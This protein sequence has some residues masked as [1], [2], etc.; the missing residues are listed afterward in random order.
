MS[1]NA[2]YIPVNCFHPFLPAVDLTLVSEIWSHSFTEMKPYTYISTLRQIMTVK[3]ICEVMDLPEQS[4]KLKVLF[5][6]PGKR[7]E[8]VLIFEK[9]LNC[10]IFV[11][12]IVLYAME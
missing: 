4:W 9:F 11:V 8:N 12:E 3:H 6:R 10:S 1:S 5:S 7:M 2:T